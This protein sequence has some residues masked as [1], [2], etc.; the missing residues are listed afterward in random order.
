MKKSL[1]LCA[2]LALGSTTGVHASDAEHGETLYR[3]YCVQCHGLSG[4]GDG[5]N[6]PALSVQ[7]RNH[8][9]TAEMSARSDEELFK[10]IKH[11]GKSINKSV[12][13]PAWG[14]N[15]DDDEIHALVSHL[16]DLCCRNGE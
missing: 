13:M 6:V 9:D 12:L 5:V 15:L 14:G 8:R 16:R 2:A 10:A 11:G 3:A 4:N 7:P 1:L